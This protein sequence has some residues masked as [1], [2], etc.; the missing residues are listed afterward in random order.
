MNTT[1][2][3]QH[4][5]RTAVYDAAGRF[6]GYVHRDA[7]NPR[8]WVASVRVDRLSRAAERVE[9]IDTATRRDAE[10]ELRD[11]ARRNVL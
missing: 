7:V 3:H 8:R 4:Y 2:G 6:I 10:L 11:R 9:G 5:P 1:A